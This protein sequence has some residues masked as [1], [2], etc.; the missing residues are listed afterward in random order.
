MRKGCIAGFLLPISDG[1]HSRKGGVGEVG[2]LDVELDD[3]A[4]EVRNE[5]GDDGRWRKYVFRYMRREAVT[6]G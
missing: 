4:G 5:E 2:R 3:F 6:Q 1:L